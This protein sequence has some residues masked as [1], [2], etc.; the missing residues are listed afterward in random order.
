[1]AGSWRSMAT[2]AHSMLRPPPAAQPHSPC[3]LLCAGCRTCK[4]ETKPK[5]P[6]FTVIVNGGDGGEAGLSLAG[7]LPGLAAQ[8]RSLWAARSH[9]CR[10]ISFG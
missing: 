1:M 2:S 5:R 9:E 4:H 3:P 10:L 8:A 7:Q 6:E